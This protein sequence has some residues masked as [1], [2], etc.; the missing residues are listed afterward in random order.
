[1]SLYAHAESASFVA[2]HCAPLILI[3]TLLNEIS[4]VDRDRT[5]NALI[6]FETLAEDDG[7]FHLTPSQETKS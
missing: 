6:R 7:Y 1:M 2:F 4:L 5:L 3:N